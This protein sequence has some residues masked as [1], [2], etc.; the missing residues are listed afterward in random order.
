M[1]NIETIV[2]LELHE[3]ICIP[4]FLNNCE[5]WK[6]TKKEEMELEKIEL[7]AIK[8]FFN[9]PIHTPSV[10]IVY[11]LGLLYTTQRID[12]IQ[13]L[14]LQKI[15]KRNDIDWAKSILNTLK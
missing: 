12:Q 1:G 15:L 10:A 7:Q 14:Y 2:I 11:T 3:K 13:L 5:S 8:Y 9:L 6:L 4:G